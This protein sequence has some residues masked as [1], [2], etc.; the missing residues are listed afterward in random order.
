[1]TDKFSVLLVGAGSMGG[2]LLKGWLANGIIDAGKSGVADPNISPGLK[3]LCDANGVRC[4]G[5]MEQLSPTYL[6]F[7]VKPQLAK[8][9]L[10]KFKA[11]AARSV[12]IS[13][14]AG[15]SIKTVRSELSDGARIVRAMPNLPA[16]MGAGMTGLY[17]EDSVAPKERDEIRSLFEAVGRAVEVSSEEAI[18]AVTAISGSGPAYFFYFTEALEKA[19]IE[20]GL[21]LTVARDLARQTLVGAGTMALQD[22]REISAMREAV[23]S[24]GGTTEAALNILKNE[25]SLEKLMKQAAVSA[26]LRA[27]QLAD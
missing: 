9:V 10:P 17:A 22:D 3:V 26:A 11:L 25:N 18:D 20:L 12:S 14:M 8:T 7:A 5:A 2:A 23:T 16:A 1:M 15:V 27:K 6:L 21:P 4:D 13:V 24:P 19:A